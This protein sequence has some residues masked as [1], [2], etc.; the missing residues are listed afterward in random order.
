M[1]VHNSKTRSYNM[2][3]IK[4]S[5]TKPEIIVRKLCH[6]VGLRFRLNQKIAGTKPDLLL[7][8]YRTAIFVHG[9]FW[10]SHDCK[11]GKV[12]PKTNMGFWL[13]KREK[14]KIRDTENIASLG[15]NDWKALVIWECELKDISAG[16]AIIEDHFFNSS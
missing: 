5:D 14:T 4:G 12:V 2:S 11:Y 1:D 9:C 16:K 8:K 15:R 3:R 10:H 6:A 7:K 13:D